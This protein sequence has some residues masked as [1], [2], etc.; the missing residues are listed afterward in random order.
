LP[1]SSPQ[2]DRRA[3][4]AAATSIAPIAALFI[5]ALALRP[6]LSSIGPLADSIITD[7]GVGHAFVGLL[8]AIP[9]VCMGLFAVLGP[10]LAPLTGVRPGIAISVAVLLLF[11]VLRAVVPGAIPLLLLTFGVGVG[12]G[13][14]G[15][16]LPMFVR[17][18]LPGQVVAGTA[19]YA[20]GTITGAALG[21]GVV[22]PLE[23]VL[24]GWQQALLAISLLSTLALIAWLLLVRRLP[25]TAQ[26]DRPPRRLTRPKLPVRRPIAWLIGILFAMQSWLFYGTIAW[27]APVY[28]ER[29]WEPI[30]AA[31]LVT[32]VN[33]TSLAA[34][35]VVPWLSGRGLSRRTLL[36]TTS[37][38][39]ATG[40]TG[41]SVAPDGALLWAVTIGLGLGMAFTLILTLPVDIAAD[42]VEVGGAA[43]LMFLVGYLLAAV[44]PFALGAIRDATGDFAISL[45]LL[46]A[47]ACVMAPLCWSLNPKRLRPPAPVPVPTPA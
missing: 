22:V 35:V 44:A 13:T 19:A 18:R 34:I 5:V 37:L 26:E 31:G 1:A 45:W 41:V 7:L 36:V 10:A 25:G 38:L 12:T 32:L 39:A 28:E 23:T 2:P 6:Q 43:A 9:V 40:L 20:G 33:A 46:V 11:A 16:L 27:L 29:G 24:G 14:I 21:S 30:A 8:T 47:I 3:T 15:P 17:G 42:P 4:V